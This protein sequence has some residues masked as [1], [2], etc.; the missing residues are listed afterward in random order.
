MK[1]PINKIAIIGAGAWGTALAMQFSSNENLQEIAIWSRDAEVANEINQ[2][3]TNSGYLPNLLSKKITCS[4][5]VDEVLANAQVVFMV[6]PSQ[7]TRKILEEIGAKMQDKIVVCCSKG[8][9][10]PTKKFMFE[11]YEEFLPK[12]QIFTLS[13]PN[14]ADEIAN[15]LPAAS[16]I[17]GD[18]IEIAK[19]LA[20][21]F[22]NNN[23]RLYFS[24]DQI[25]VQIGGALKNVLAI[26]AGILQ[27]K[28]LGENALAA[29]IARSL[30]EMSQFAVAKNGKA[31]T[32]MGLS[33]VGD[34][35]L[36]AS[37]PEKSRNAKFGFLLAKGKK[38]EEILEKGTF[39][40][41]STVKA[42]HE[43]TKNLKIEMPICNAVYKIIYE[44]AN[45]DETINLLFARKISFE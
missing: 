9:E 24:N 38:I 2:K 14:F 44:N 15:S 20:E 25:S 43:I 11:L 12:S 33:G 39:E 22:S 23:F 37:N 1:L 36:T 10:I 3:H 26:A 27:A 32:L 30:K 35:I 17:A 8:I 34:L 6:V 28:N 29:L 19:F 45:I 21:F 31:E 5:N 18:D 16:V 13:G 40:G 42:L 4:T 7:K 41:H